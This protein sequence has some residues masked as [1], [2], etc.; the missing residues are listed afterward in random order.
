MTDTMHVWNA[1][2]TPPRDALKEVTYGRKFTSIDAYWCIR[3]ATRLFGPIGFGW[4]Y[5]VNHDLVELPGKGGPVLYVRACMDLW[6]RI[7]EERSEP[8]R[9]YDL[10]ELSGTRNT[11]ERHID[12]E[13]HK[14]ATTACISKALSYIGI[15]SDI[16]MGKHEGKY[17]TEAPEAQRSP[18]TIDA[19]KRK[20]LFAAWAAKAASV[21]IEGDEPLRKMV[22]DLGFSSSADIT[23]DAYDALLAA[24]ESYDPNAITSIGEEGF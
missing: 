10:I 21:G 20:R 7:G 13:A 3:E 2:A 11:G 5:S 16:F 6:Y 18:R 12:D 22:S 14:K 8:V 23:L 9:V 17:R 1:A 4:G 15:A 19:A 24:I